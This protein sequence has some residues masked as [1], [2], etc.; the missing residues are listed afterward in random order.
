MV[1]VNVR[2]DTADESVSLK[3]QMYITLGKKCIAH[4]LSFYAFMSKNA[5][6][7]KNYTR[8]PVCPLTKSKLYKPG[9]NLWFYF[10]EMSIAN[11]IFGGYFGHFTR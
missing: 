2:P 8:L 4:F 3:L 9:L 6:Y 11:I 5:F 1:Q 10:V 7:M